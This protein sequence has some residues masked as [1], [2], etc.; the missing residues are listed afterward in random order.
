M[1][2]ERWLS[3]FQKDTSASKLKKAGGGRE[4]G[5]R[6]GKHSLKAYGIHKRA[7]HQNKDSFKRAKET[8]D[9]C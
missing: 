9:G 7:E 5:G 1:L 6:E 8:L 3:C 2:E 4:S